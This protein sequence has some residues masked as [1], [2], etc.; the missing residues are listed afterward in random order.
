MR[1]NGSTVA[2]LKASRSVRSSEREPFRRRA[3][4]RRLELQRDAVH[5]IAIAGRRRPVGKDVSEMP[6][7][8][9]AVDLDSRHPVAAVGGRPDC[10]FDWPVK[11]R[12]AGPT[13]IFRRRR[14][15]WLSAARAAEGAGALLLQQRTAAAVLRAVFT[16][17]PELLRREDRLPVGFCFFGHLTGTV[18]FSTAC[19][20][21]C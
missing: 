6:A 14:E 19:A 21:C 2:R 17:H 5:A 12:P 9:A 1:R 13:L 15:Q 7:A 18:A 4:L 11:A 16:Q 3:S 8:T 10:A 20:F